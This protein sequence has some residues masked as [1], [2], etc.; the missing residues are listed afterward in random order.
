[1][2]KIIRRILTIIPAVALQ[3]LWLL[4]LMKWLTPYAPIIVS[5]LSVAAFFLVV[6]IIIKRDETA[7][8][9][10]WLLVILSLPLVGALLYLL[11]GN[12]RTARPLKRRLQ[13][14]QKSC[15]PQPL[16]IK[17]APFDGEK[18]MGQTV[19]WLEEKTQYPMCAVEQVRYYPLGDNMFPDMLADLKNAR[20][21]IYV[22]YFIIE[23]GH[24]WDAI[25]NELEVKMEQGVDVRVIYD[26]LGSISSFNF[27]NV[28][29]LKKKGIPCIPFNPFLALKGTANYRDHRKMLIIDNE[30]AYSGGINLS[31]RYINLEHPYG[32]WKD[33][34]FRI[35]GEPVKNFTHMFLT[36]WNAF[37][38]EK[39]AGQLAMPTYPKRY[40]APPHTFDGYVLSYYDSPLNHEATSNQLFI[41]LLSQ[42]TDYAWF[43]TPYLM[44]GDD[45]MDAMISA[46]QRGVDV[47]IIMPGIPDKKLIFRMSRSFY[48]VLLTG[49]IKIEVFMKHFLMC[50]L[51]IAALGVLSFVVGRLIPKHWFHADRFP[52][53]CHPAEQKL[54]KRLHV[55]KWQAKIP[56]MSRIFVKIMPEKKLTKENYENLPRM[57]EE[58]CVAEWTHILLSIAGLG[59]LKI[60]SGVGGVCITIIYIVLGNLP[61]IVVQRYNRPRLQKLFAMQQRKK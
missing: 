24:M 45:L 60:W 54:W 53:V 33:T 49:G 11:F 5:L 43:F 13:Q 19:R 6:F 1:M 58:T 31:D 4:L 21:S 44:L 26:D 15:N 48:Q 18:R 42:S 47:R 27:S 2:G 59:L 23:P 12:K 32:H 52:W 35:T 40:P 28:R 16:P 10:L 61:F 8:K 14:V 22:E 39:E 29:E 50:L 3:S 34:G 46:A 17:E 25:V 57:I 56:D 9:L 30:V 37:S 51:Y 55:R 36:F 20:N 7:Y 38:L 41:D